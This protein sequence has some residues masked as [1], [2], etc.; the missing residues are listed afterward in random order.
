MVAATRTTPKLA[1]DLE[2]GSQQKVRFHSFRAP[3]NSIS[4]S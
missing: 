4:V 2:D 1:S 3:S